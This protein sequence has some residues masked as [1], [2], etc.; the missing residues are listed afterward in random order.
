MTLHPMADRQ[1]AADRQFGDM[2]PDT[3]SLQQAEEPF[4]V[5]P[6]PAGMQR[7]VVG[8]SLDS[9][10]ERMGFEPSVPLVSEP[11]DSDVRGG[12]QAWIVLSRKNRHSVCGTC[13][14]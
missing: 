6:E 13:G 7:D 11:P 14:P 1:S 3:T 4:Q 12:P 10:L 9:P 8:S 5:L 2:R